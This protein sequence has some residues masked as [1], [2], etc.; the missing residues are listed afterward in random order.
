[1]VTLFNYLLP[2]LPVHKLS[3]A[4]GKQRVG[5]EEENDLQMPVQ[6]SIFQLGD[7][8]SLCAWCA[9]PWV[10][11][12]PTAALLVTHLLLPV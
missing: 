12:M 10:S 7:E 5:E 6:L 4:P 3:L 9:L 8:Y 1:M 2:A 11:Q